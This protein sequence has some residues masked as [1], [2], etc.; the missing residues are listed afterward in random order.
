MHRLSDHVPEV[1]LAAGV[2][3]DGGAPPCTGPPPLL[4][5]LLVVLVLH[6]VAA[7]GHAH[8]LVEG[9]PLPQLVAAVVDG[10]GPARPLVRQAAD[11]RDDCKR[12]RKTLE[13]KNSIVLVTGHIVK[14]SYFIFL[15]QNKSTLKR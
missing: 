14:V 15:L 12:K 2:G 13:P 8:D 7:E 6:G 9:R 11:C 10:E 4:G 3:R 1:R 5:L